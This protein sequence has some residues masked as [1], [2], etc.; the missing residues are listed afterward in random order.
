MENGEL[1][2]FKS[3]VDFSS[4]SEQLERLQWEQ[5]VY[6]DAEEID[7]LLLA[8]K[9]HFSNTVSRSEESRGGRVIWDLHHR[10]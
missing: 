1:D 7:G 6:A 5:E 2:Y 10:D 4:G 9:A 3:P 8:N